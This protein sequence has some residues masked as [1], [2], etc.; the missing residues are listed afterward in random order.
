M[1]KYLD[2]VPFQRITGAEKTQM[3]YGNSLPDDESI[4]TVG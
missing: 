4:S 2:Y 1:N 3:L